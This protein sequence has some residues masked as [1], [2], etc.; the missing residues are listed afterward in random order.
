MV[1]FS[2]SQPFLDAR[3]IPCQLAIELF[4]SK[5]DEMLSMLEGDNARRARDEVRIVKEYGSMKAYTDMLDKEL[6][7]GV[8][9]LERAEEEG[10]RWPRDNG[11]LLEDSEGVPRF[12]ERVS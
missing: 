12:D 2:L 8:V 10:H 11:G 1:L 5:L 6:N 4:E 3:E 7:F 9:E